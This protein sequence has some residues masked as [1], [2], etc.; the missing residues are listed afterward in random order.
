ML[1]SLLHLWKWCHLSEEI[2][3][4]LFHSSSNRNLH[5]LSCAPLCK[6]IWVCLHFHSC[7]NYFWLH[8]ERFTL[9]NWDWGWTSVLQGGIKKVGKIYKYPTGRGVSKSWCYQLPSIRIDTTTQLWFL[10]SLVIQGTSKGWDSRTE[11]D[12]DTSQRT[13]ISSSEYQN[14]LLLEYPSTEGWQQQLPRVHC[15]ISL[16]G[17]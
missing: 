4:V 10:S 6:R 8:P 3:N 12:I 14:G 13:W 1:S 9:Q 5:F 7:K 2:T 17:K 16:Q 11:L 15:F